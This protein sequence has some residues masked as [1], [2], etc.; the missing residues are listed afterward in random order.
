MRHPLTALFALLVIASYIVVPKP[1]SAHG[2][3][4]AGPR[5][6]TVRPGD[7]LTRIAA[8]SGLPSWYPLYAANRD[9]IR[10]PNLIRAGQVLVIPKSAG[11][12]PAA[13]A[14]APRQAA[15][16]AAPPA[17]GSS[18]MV[19]II[20]A[21]ALRYGQS[22]S[23]MLAVARCESGLNPRAVNPA[24]EASGLFQ[25]LPST[26]RTT[27]YA[28]ASIFDAEANANAAAWMWSV[29]RRNEWVC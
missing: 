23:A 24:S 17:A 20:T 2:I 18:T 9:R 11:T 7:T 28:N 13:L 6:Y 22:P 26:W 29:G 10:N 1:A 12:A 21:A 4:A 27:P 19:N 25:F 5:T 16:Q 14:P 3:S 15:R 8:V